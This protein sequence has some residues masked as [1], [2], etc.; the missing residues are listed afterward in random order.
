MYSQYSSWCQHKSFMFELILPRR[1]RKNVS[2]GV[3]RPHITHQ[4]P[5]RGISTLSCQNPI[6]GPNHVGHHCTKSIIVNME[7]RQRM[8]QCRR[9]PNGQVHHW[10]SGRQTHQSP[11]Q[12]HSPLM[13]CQVSTK[14]STKYQ[15]THSQNHE[16]L[17]LPILGGDC[18]RGL[19]HRQIKDIYDLAVVLTLRQL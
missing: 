15:Q 1:P 19:P 13:G 3:C 2:E 4:R 6:L 18:H 17:D 7:P 14:Q 9:S 16:A 8:F 12:L 10:I 11:R 5:C